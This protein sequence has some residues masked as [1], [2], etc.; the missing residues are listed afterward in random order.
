MSKM[1]TVRKIQTHD[2]SM[3]LDQSCVDSKVGWRPAV[4]LDIDS[5]LRWIQSK[6]FKSS[7]LSQDFNLKEMK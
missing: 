1:A 7:F 5:P 3:R 2:T 6:Q 4:W